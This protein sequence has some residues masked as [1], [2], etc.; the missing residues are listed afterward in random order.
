[1][2]MKAHCNLV[3]DNGVP[4]DLPPISQLPIGLVFGSWVNPRRRSRKNNLIK[5]ILFLDF[6]EFFIDGDAQSQG[7]SFGEALVEMSCA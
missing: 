6:S 3:K 7:Q 2:K 5:K 1:M 4:G